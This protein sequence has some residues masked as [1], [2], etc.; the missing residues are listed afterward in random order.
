ML[1]QSYALIVIFV[2]VLTWFVT[3]TSK[4]FIG[5]H[6]LIGYRTKTTDKK[7]TIQ[8]SLATYIKT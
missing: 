5:E 1:F 2:I 7:A 8:S 3:S 4:C 6:A